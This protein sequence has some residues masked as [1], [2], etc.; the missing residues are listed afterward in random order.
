MR[1]RQW[2]EKEEPQQAGPR[3]NV[4]RKN[5]TRLR[6]RQK[7]EALVYL[8]FSL[9][10]AQDQHRQAAVIRWLAH[11]LISSRQRFHSTGGRAAMADRQTWSHGW[12]T[13]HAVSFASLPP[14]R[15]RGIG[16]GQGKSSRADWPG[17]VAAGLAEVETNCDST[18]PRSKFPLLQ[19]W[20]SGLPALFL[21]RGG[22][23]GHLVALA[24]LIGD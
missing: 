23:G 13:A 8:G 19:G 3:H 18:H 9:L 17:T 1:R 12:R 20:T 5:T 15:P 10:P 24:P 16:A 2:I 22:T 11:G 6:P 21:K 7:E 14:S 4:E